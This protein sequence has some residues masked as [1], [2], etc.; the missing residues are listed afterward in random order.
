MLCY[1]AAWA[2]GHRKGI[3]AHTRLILTK[4]TPSS[5]FRFVIQFC[6]LPVCDVLAILSFIH[7]RLSHSR[8]VVW[9]LRSGLSV[10]KRWRKEP[11][12]VWLFMI[13][14]TIIVFS[15]KE[16]R[17]ESLDLIWSLFLPLQEFSATSDTQ[18]PVC[19]WEN[20]PTAD[21][22]DDEEF[23]HVRPVFTPRS[24]IR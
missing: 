24:F 12:K 23:P 15:V 16:I 19:S 14:C 18:S 22:W 8:P 17:K 5:T 2:W 9:I 21:G 20:R 13:S 4:Q 11:Q 1:S 10:P 7:L 3:I 6:T